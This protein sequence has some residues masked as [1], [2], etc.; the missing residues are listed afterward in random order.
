MSDRRA[1][2][3]PREERPA[4][5]HRKRRHL[6]CH[7]RAHCRE[8]GACFASV[9]AFDRHRAGPWRER[10]CRIPLGA[11]ELVRGTCQ[12]DCEPQVRAVWRLAVAADRARR[13]FEGPSAPEREAVAA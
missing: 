12:I 13:H 2:G 1:T 4:S 8:C 7:C 5:L 3:R 11:F 9:D 10:Y 6:A